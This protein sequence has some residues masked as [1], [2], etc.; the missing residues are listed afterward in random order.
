MQKQSRKQCRN[1]KRWWRDYT[2][3]SIPSENLKWVT[4]QSIKSTNVY[5]QKVNAS[6]EKRNTN[7]RA[8]NGNP[9][10]L[11]LYRYEKLRANRG[12]KS[13]KSSG[14]RMKRGSSPTSPAKEK[15][16]NIN[17]LYMWLIGSRILPVKFLSD[18]PNTSIFVFILK[19]FVTFIIYNVSLITLW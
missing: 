5:C 8:L 4:R 19:L 9:G 6:L 2:W 17:Y 13:W 15:E 11:S 12:E 10:A 14:E 1:S 7:K 16:I 3:I 18:S